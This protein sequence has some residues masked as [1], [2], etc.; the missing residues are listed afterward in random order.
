MTS[1]D[2]ALVREV[3]EALSS[4]GD[5]DR[6]VGQRAYMKSAMPFHGITSPELTALLRPLLSEFGPTTRSEWER[7]ILELWDGATHREERYAALAVARMR[8]ARAWCD[9]ESLG[10]FRHLVTT[11]A[12]WDFVDVIAAHLVGLALAE[13][14]PTVSPVLIEWARDGDLWVRRTAVLS[15]L[16]HQQDTDRHFLAAVIEANLDDPSFWLRKSIGWALREFARTDPEWVRSHVEEWGPR[17]SP[18]SRREALKHL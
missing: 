12:W 9:L 14:R 10:L 2:L 16:R 3:R 7:V 18:L 13:H 17:L 11:G 4:A 1:P 6:A 8:R 15:Q 5:P